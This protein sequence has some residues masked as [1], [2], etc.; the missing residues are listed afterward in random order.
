MS[1][2][3][4]YVFR[5]IHV[6]FINFVLNDTGRVAE[7][8]VSTA[9]GYPYRYRINY[10]RQSSGVIRPDHQSNNQYSWSIALLSVTTIA[11]ALIADIATASIVITE[12]TV[13]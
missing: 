2:I 9:Y 5:S 10:T 12:R 13:K 11:A 6:A 7:R 3:V 4:A 8:V 1:Y